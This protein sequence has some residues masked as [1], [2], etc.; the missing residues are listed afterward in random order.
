MRQLYIKI[1]KML[2]RTHAHRK[3]ICTFSDSIK[4]DIHGFKGFV[5]I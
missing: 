3:P 1:Q 2:Q 5:W 4:L